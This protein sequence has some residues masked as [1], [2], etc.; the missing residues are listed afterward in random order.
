M[1]DDVA[2]EVPPWYYYPIKTLPFLTPDDFGPKSC[3]GKKSNLLLCDLSMMANL[4]P[5]FSWQNCSAVSWLY[6]RP[7][8]RKHACSVGEIS[9]QTSS[10]TWFSSFQPICVGGYSQMKFWGCEQDSMKP[11]WSSAL[12]ME[13]HS[14]SY[15]R[16][17]LSDG[18]KRLSTLCVGEKMC[19][20]QKRRDINE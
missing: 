8:N 10:P 16:E 9:R 11:H 18:I 14:S 20:G 13:R 4:A 6:C 17:E 7:T 5:R 19:D 3:L 15:Q 12:E 2:F 1:S